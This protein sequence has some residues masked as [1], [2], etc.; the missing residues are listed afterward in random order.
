M[1]CKYC[2]SEMKFVFTNEWVCEYGDI[3]GIKMQ[4]DYAKRDC[5]MIIE[6]GFKWCAGCTLCHKE[7]SISTSDR[8][9]DEVKLSYITCPITNAICDNRICGTCNTWAS[10]CV[11]HNLQRVDR[12]GQQNKMDFQTQSRR[13][14]RRQKVQDYIID[15]FRM[16]WR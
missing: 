7:S 6:T 13:I 4:C 16:F 2:Q 1:Q 14:S 9:Q 8:T 10:Y 5:I 3:W 15:W 12:Y 11:Q